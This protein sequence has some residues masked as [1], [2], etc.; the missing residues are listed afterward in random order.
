MGFT[1]RHKLLIRLN[2]LSHCKRIDKQILSRNF[3]LFE[4]YWKCGFVILIFEKLRLYHFK[5]KRNLR[6]KLHLFED[7]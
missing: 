7:E 1:L 6:S 2:L 4:F 5:M 3:G